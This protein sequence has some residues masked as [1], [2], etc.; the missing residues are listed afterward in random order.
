MNTI[1]SN[2]HDLSILKDHLFYSIINFDIIIGI[3]YT[4]PW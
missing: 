3:S 4:Q 1:Q 2:N